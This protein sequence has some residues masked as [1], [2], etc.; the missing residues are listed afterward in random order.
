MR[1]YTTP[2]P[3]PR[4]RA[5]GHLTWVTEERV[6]NSELLKPENLCNTKIFS[7]MQTLRNHLGL[8]FLHLQNEDGI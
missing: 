8:D 3:Q 5:W 6:S 2:A 7:S 4:L 1:G